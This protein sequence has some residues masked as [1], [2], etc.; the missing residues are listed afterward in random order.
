MGR[1]EAVFEIS[2]KSNPL[3]YTFTSSV[4]DFQMWTDRMTDH[5]CRSTQRWRHVLDFIAKSTVP[6]KKSCLVANNLDGI[7]A[8]DIATM[9]ESFMV[10]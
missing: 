8:W 9:L 1:W 4:A 6:V 7:N 5:L 10:D 2:R 3:L